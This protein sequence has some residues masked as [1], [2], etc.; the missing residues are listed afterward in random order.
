MKA[1]LKYFIGFF[2]LACLGNVK[3]QT[4]AFN[5]GGDT[6]V[7]VLWDLKEK[8]TIAGF[9][10]YEDIT[11]NQNRVNEIYY[12]NTNRFTVAFTNSQGIKMYAELLLKQ[13]NQVRVKVNNANYLSNIFLPKMYYGK[14]S[15][16][17]AVN[18]VTL[19][20]APGYLNM[21]VYLTNE[22]IT[23]EKIPLDGQTGFMLQRSNEI[24]FKPTPYQCAIGE[25]NTNKVQPQKLPGNNKANSVASS[26]DKCTYVFIDCTNKLHIRRGSNIQNTINYVYSIWNDLNTLYENEQMHVKISEINVW[27]T[28]DPFSTSSTSEAANR[29]F[30]DYYKDN[31]WGNMAMLLDFSGVNGGIA[32]GYG[33]AK[34]LAPNVC[35][36]YNPTPNPSWN[37]GSFAYCNFNS[38]RNLQ[39][40]PTP[41]IA[42]P[43]KVCAHELGHLFNSWHTHSCNWAGGPI[44]NC[45]AKEGTCANEGAPPVNGGTIMSYC[46]QTDAGI[47]FNNGFG[48]LPGNSIRA[49]VGSNACIS[50]CSACPLFENTG[51]ITQQGF[52]HIEAVFVSANGTVP[53]ANTFIKLDGGASVTLAPGFKALQGSK[54]NVYIDGCGGIR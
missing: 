31:Y 8:K 21:Q 12:S 54:V 47:N 18:N 51:T 28:A 53:N 42:W 32:G 25:D 17:N 49:W 10:S 15:G 33:W 36:T 30:A 35:G 39:N 34:G 3:G 16:V 44:D 27:V 14:V 23:I 45:V 24:S 6:T 20:L 43:V 29:S 2:L 38:G 19:T 7:T 5:Q 46:D 22:T 1:K 11:I 26:T 37:F 4:A 9:G 52:H 50:D 48:P 40:F 13:M 41:D